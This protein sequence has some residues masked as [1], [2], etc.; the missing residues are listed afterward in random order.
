[1]YFTI[2]SHIYQIKKDMKFGRGVSEE[3]IIQTPSY[4]IIVY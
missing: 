3:S 4:Y 1:M 2:Y